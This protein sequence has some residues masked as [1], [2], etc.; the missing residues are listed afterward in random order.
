[1]R[2]SIRCRKALVASAVQ[3]ENRAGDH[4]TLELELSAR[5]ATYCH[6]MLFLW[7]AMTLSPE[8]KEPSHVHPD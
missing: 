8:R 5:G 6:R 1:M 4:L 3:E 2:T 7:V